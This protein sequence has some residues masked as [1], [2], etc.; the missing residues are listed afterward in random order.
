MPNWVFNSLTIEGNETDLRAFIEKASKPYTTYYKGKFIDNAD[1]TKNYDA[2]AINVH[3]HESPLS[4]M[5]FTSPE[6]LDTYYSEASIK[7]DNYDEMTFDE[8]LNYSLRFS[9]DGWYDWNVRNW[10]T[11]WDACDVVVDERQLN[12]G[13]LAYHFST[14]WSPAEGAYQRMVEQHPTLTF[15]FH[16][17]EEQGWGVEYDSVSGELVETNSWDIPNSHADYVGRDN[18]DGCVCS[19][20]DDQDEWYNDCPKEEEI[21]EQSV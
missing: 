21:V 12:V 2:D 17:E 3:V 5:N 14:A 15:S 8:R 7:P 19:Y 10:G 16:C 6:D 4:F 13:V 18:E 1:G 11:K 20:E 9:T